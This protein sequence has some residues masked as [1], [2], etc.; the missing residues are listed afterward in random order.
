[1][2]TRYCWPLLFTLLVGVAHA[3]APLQNATTEELLEKLT[4]APPQKT[5]SLNRNMVVDAQASITKT[6]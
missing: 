6:A 4:P 2:T 3:Q 5:R 1:M